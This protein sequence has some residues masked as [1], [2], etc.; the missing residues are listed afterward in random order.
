MVGAAGQQL[1][2][3]ADA[4]IAQALRAGEAAGQHLSEGAAAAHSEDGDEAMLTT[5]P[6]QRKKRWGPLARLFSGLYVSAC[7]FHAAGVRS[8]QGPVLSL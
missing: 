2:M 7:S 3:A 6:K 8:A 1:V 4:A 5:P